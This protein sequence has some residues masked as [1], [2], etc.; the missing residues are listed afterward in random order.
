MLEAIRSSIPIQKIGQ[1]RISEID[2]DHIPFGKI[3]SDH[4]LVAEYENG[5]WNPAKIMPYDQI[6]M[7][8]CIMALHYGQSIFEGLKAFKM[9]DGSSALFRP[10]ANYNRMNRSAAGVVMP[11]IPKEIFM[12][13]LLELVKLDS[14]WIPDRPES[15]LYIRPIY[16]A[17]DETIGIKSSDKYKFVIFTCPVGAYYPEP[18]LLWAS[19]KYVRAF[20]GGMGEIKAAGNYAGSLYANKIAK[21]KGYHNV[22]WLD[23]KE[24]KY[25]EECGTMNIFFVID[26]KVITPSLGGTILHG[27][28]RDSCITLLKDEGIEVEQRRISLDEIIAASENGTLEDCFG[29][30]TAATVAPVAKIGMEER[31]LELPPVANRKISNMLLKTL[32]GIRYGEIEDK[33]GWMVK[34]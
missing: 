5:K 2:F 14:N 22:L 12:D 6:L 28:T 34:V 4:M 9:K 29:A 30:G 16:F 15:A 27:I 23:G 10:E 7:Y 18:V 13:G 3:F 11:E 1:S 17:T 25:I 21:D 19:K 26:G 20:E 31:V 8:P 33:H 32:N 24:H